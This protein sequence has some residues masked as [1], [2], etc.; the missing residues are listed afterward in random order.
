[1]SI[2]LLDNVVEDNYGSIFYGGR[3]SEPLLCRL[4]DG[5]VFNTGLSMTMFYGD[6]LL[7]QVSEIIDRVV[8]AGLY[9]FWISLST[10][11]RKSVT[12]KISL[13]HPLDIYY[14]FNLNHLEPAFYLLLLGCCLSAICFMLE[15]FYNRVLEKKV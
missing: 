3:N 10:N 11:M 12:R 15:V 4:E 8:E 5:V 9:N 7:R 6:P 1:V 14:S 13:V 2:L